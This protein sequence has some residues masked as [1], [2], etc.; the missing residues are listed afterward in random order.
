MSKEY[1]PFV[2]GARRKHLR[3]RVIKYT[4]IGLLIVIILLVLALPS[5]LSTTAGKNI[6][7]T[8]IQKATGSTVTMSELSLGWLSG[9]EIKDLDYNDPINN[10]T[11]TAKRFAGKP[12]ITSLI[13]GKLSLEEGILETPNVNIFLKKTK[14]IEQS[15]NSGHPISKNTTP[16]IKPDFPKGLTTYTQ[17]AATTAT[18]DNSNNF[19][20]ELIDLKITD[21]NLKIDVEQNIENSLTLSNINSEFD[22]NPRGQLSS[23]KLSLMINSNTETLNLNTQAQRDLDNPYVIT[24]AN[25]D[26]NITKLDLA[27]LQPLL[28]FL[29][30]NTTTNGI[31]DGNIK[32][33]VKDSQLEMFQ[34]EIKGQ[35][36]LIGGELLKNDTISTKTLEFNADAYS[37]KDHVNISN[38][39]LNC[40]WASIN[41]SGA[42]P[43]NIEAIINYMHPTTQESF[44]ADYN[45]DI[46]HIILMMPNVIKLKKNMSLN[47]GILKGHLDII[48]KDKKRS[49]LANMNIDKFRLTINSIPIIFVKPIFIDLDTYVNDS[50]MYINNAKLDSYV[51][52]FEAKGTQN[53]FQ[54]DSNINLEKAHSMFGK[55][56]GIS[57]YQ[58][59]GKLNTKGTANLADKIITLTSNSNIND[60]ELTHEKN[61][62]YES[63]IKTDST[64]KYYPQENG[65]QIDSFNLNCNTADIE[66]TNS[67][68][69]LDENKFPAFD[70]AIKNRVDLSRISLYSNLFSDALN[71]TKLKGK[72][73]ST[74]NTRLNLG[75]IALRSDDILLED[76]ELVQK[77]KEPFKTKNLQ[78][79]I[80]AALEANQSYTAKL[81]E[82]NSSEGINAIFTDV[83][84][85]IAQPQKNIKLLGKLDYDLAKLEPKLNP[86][87]PKN[88]EILGTHQSNIKIAST[89]DESQNQKLT[90]NLNANTSLA[91]DSAT[92]S[93]LNIGKTIIPLS[94]NN[95]LLTIEQFTS[96]VNNGKLNLTGA[97]DLKDE[98]L[99]FK[100]TEPIQ[101]IENIHINQEIIDNYLSNTNPLFSNAVATDGIINFH[102]NNLELPLGEATKKSDISLKGKIAIDQMNLS[103][104]MLNNLVMQFGKQLSTQRIDILPTNF[105]MQNGILSYDDTMQINLGQNP[106]NFSG[107]TG[108]QDQL[109][110][111][112]SLPYTTS[113]KLLYIGQEN[114]P[115]RIPPIAIKGTLS[116]PQI[117][118]DNLIEETTNTIIEKE[119][120][121]VLEKE[122]GDD[123]KDVIDTGKKILENLFK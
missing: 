86:Y 8:Q 108:P 82:L 73:T 105:T 118:I 52:T 115:D 42:I 30:L 19:E 67:S 94:I 83:V 27:N 123:A 23:A 37:D 99:K 77:D 112:V 96:P 113:G 69:I 31:I 56:L 85:D 34:G 53:N 9:V 58:I 46:A 36:L 44:S 116:K 25:A 65:I 40:D 18:D 48:T 1:S 6:V 61:I 49:T 45:I 66:I 79:K 81:I 109:N 5:L 47:S 29:S 76:F 78:A 2:K 22:I 71:D 16:L 7:I 21:G 55:L 20:I 117:N 28:D 87:L 120:E 14:V 15:I 104:P 70:L 80:D 75:S 106:L 121:K 95:G 12:D 102:I 68:I 72:L 35:E 91:F 24:N 74:I 10:I 114:D 98:Q 64:I 119:L 110:M 59:A 17:L 84:I 32:A 60:L 97:I 100:I 26:I 4:T 111:K 101:L 38:L 107:S 41:A 93:G 103:S 89:W 3:K 57:D 88:L 90:D 62:A 11:L 39:N 51:G 54:F 33:K 43:K 63:L 13:M 122:I 92:M 50:G